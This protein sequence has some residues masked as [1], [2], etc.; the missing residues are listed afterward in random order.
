MRCPFCGH[1][2][3]QV[4]DSRPTED[5]A[6]IRRRRQCEGCGQRAERDRQNLPR[7]GFGTD[8]R[9]ERAEQGRA[10]PGDDREH[11]HLDP[12]GDDM[13]EH[14]FGHERG[15]VPEG[16]GQQDESGQRHQLELDQGD[17]Y[18]DGDNEEGE[19][20]DQIGEQ[21]HGDDREIGERRPEAVIG[22]HRVDQWLRRIE[23]LCSDR[24]G[25]HELRE[26]E[27]IATRLE[28][29]PREAVEQDRRQCLEIADD[30][31]EGADIEGFLYSLVI[32][33][34]GG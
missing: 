17:E 11:Q 26:A 8:R 15:A 24:A 23:T 19:D 28:P 13:A 6:A 33:G 16:E 25:L 18:L 3:S 27:G 1:E 21:Q 14:F 12:A 32:V 30:E 2:D 31:G 34:C 7:V 5:G 4:K 10:D 29:Q 9:R 22:L 20:D